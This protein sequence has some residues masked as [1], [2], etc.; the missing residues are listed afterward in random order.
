MSALSK[1]FS[2]SKLNESWRQS[3]W[4]G[5]S[6][7]SEHIRDP[8]APSNLAKII[9]KKSSAV[10]IPLLIVSSELMPV[11]KDE[12]TNKT[13]QWGSTVKIFWPAGTG[14]DKDVVSMIE[15]AFRE[16][17][18]Y[19]RSE[20]SNE[21]LYENYERLST[22]NKG[23]TTWECN[24]SNRYIGDPQVVDKLLSA[25]E[26]PAS[27]WTAVKKLGWAGDVRAIDPLINLLQSGEYNIPDF[28]VNLFKKDIA[29]S[30]IRLEDTHG[31]EV[32]LK[33]LENLF[34]S[35]VGYEKSK[36]ADLLVQIG[37]PTMQIFIDALNSKDDQT[38][39]LSTSALKD[40]GDARAVEPLVALLRRKLS[41]LV[42]EHAEEALQQIRAPEAI[43]P[44]IDIVL[45]N[46]MKE[47][48]RISAVR[49][50]ASIGDNRAIEPLKT[51]MN[52]KEN[53]PRFRKVL[54]GAIKKLNEAPEG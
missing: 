54:E 13:V 19:G 5:I 18:D 25:L 34:H 4:G 51:L 20:M 46:N 28:Q 2:G 39:L 7:W 23:K 42:Y 41:S 45:D 17:E 37:S 29:E 22:E 3:K 38:L 1:L 53:P 40:I 9:A 33:E 31:K 50:L 48:R 16:V 15:N 14:R 12:K 26:D 8:K 30:L 43:E 6:L 52:N 49:V 10:D 32:A 21:N 11:G 35:E 44:L 47:P 36:V 27:R 24:F